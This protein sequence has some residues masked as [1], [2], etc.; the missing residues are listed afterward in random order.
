MRTY[1]LNRRQALPVDPETAW[2]FFSNPANLRLITPPWLD[3]NILSR[4]PDAIYT[5][6]VIT[7]SIRPLA[8]IGISWVSEITQ[9][10]PPGFFVDEQCR[11]PFSFWRHQHHLQK[12]PEGVENKDEV[13]YRLPAGPIGILVHSI[14]VRRKLEAIFD[15]RH[16][17]CREIFGSGR[18][19]S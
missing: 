5:G 8:G 4:L 14:F 6:L 17:V 3:F 18:G 16:D 19:G 1:H 2:R 13:Q 12:I 7:Y 10:K 9:V 15:F 11:G